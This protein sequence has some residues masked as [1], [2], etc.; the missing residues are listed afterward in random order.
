MWKGIYQDLLFL[1]VIS[2]YTSP[3]SLISIEVIVG[4]NGNKKKIPKFHLE[5][6]ENPNNIEKK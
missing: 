2:S 3:K 1:P 4:Y 5:K 6:E